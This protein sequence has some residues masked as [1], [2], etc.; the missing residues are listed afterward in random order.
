MRA[1]AVNSAENV[2]VLDLLNFES[3][4]HEVLLAQE[5]QTTRFKALDVST[6]TVHISYFYWQTFYLV[7]QKISVDR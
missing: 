1:V 5:W 7:C 6:M 2:F 4:S 3:L